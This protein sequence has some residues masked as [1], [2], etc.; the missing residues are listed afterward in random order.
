[1]KYAK[2]IGNQVSEILVA[3]DGFTIEECFHPEVLVGIIP[4]PD[5]VQNG[6]SLVDGVWTAPTP[7]EPESNPVA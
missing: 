1:M 6:W 4:V 3:I 2:L 7:P 5:E